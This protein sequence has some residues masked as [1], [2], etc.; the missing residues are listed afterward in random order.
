MHSKQS[1]SVPSRYIGVG[2]TVVLVRL[3]KIFTGFIEGTVVES[4]VWISWDVVLEVGEAG[5]IALVLLVEVFTVV[6]GEAVVVA[7][8]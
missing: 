3:V 6:V 7:K 5:T 1:L 2:E 8:I 4:A